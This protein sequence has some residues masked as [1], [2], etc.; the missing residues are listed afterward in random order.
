MKIKFDFV[1]NSSSTSFVYISDEELSEEVFLKAAGVDGDGL[2]GDLFR[3]MHSEI[4]TAIR[5]YGKQVTTK[6]DADSF[7]GRHEFTPEVI[8]KMKAAIK[9]GKNVVTAT[10]DSD[11]PLAESLLCMAMFEIDS[12]RFYI[13][14]YNNYW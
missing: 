9:Q 8:E 5:H 13:N 11:G 14:A 4:C 3:Q 7:A 12:E 2:V 1:S 10:L 6:D